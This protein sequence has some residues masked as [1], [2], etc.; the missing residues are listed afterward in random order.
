M[1][2]PYNFHLGIFEQPS[3]D[4]F[5]NAASKL[6]TGCIKTVPEKQ[7]GVLEVH[8]AAFPTQPLG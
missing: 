3:K 4:Y 8:S 7:L 6:N 2:C 5:L 1:N